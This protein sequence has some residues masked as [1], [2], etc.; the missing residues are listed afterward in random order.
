MGTAQAHGPAQQGAAVIVAG[1]VG[2]PGWGREVRGVGRHGVRLPVA[3][4]AGAMT[5]QLQ[6]VIADEGALGILQAEHADELLL[7]QQGAVQAGA[8]IGIGQIVVLAQHGLVGRLREAQGAPGAQ[9]PDVAAVSANGTER[10]HPQGEHRGQLLAA[11]GAMGL[12]VPEDQAIGPQALLEALQH[13]VIL[14]LAGH[15]AQARQLQGQA[16]GALLGLGLQA[17]EPEGVLLVGEGNVPEEGVKAQHQLAPLAA[18]QPLLD[19]L[20]QGVRQL[21]RPGTAGLVEPVERR[22]HHIGQGD[23]PL[24]TGI[25]AEKQ[26]RLAGGRKM[27]ERGRR[28]ELT[29][30]C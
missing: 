15:L 18:G 22:L 16:G 28:H 20:A 13:G 14:L 5:Y 23:Q 10:V 4:Q 6:G 24:T 11:K 8:D 26:G 25:Q 12:V 29:L 27:A 9:G 3:E 7:L 1:Q 30:S 2:K 21:G 19:R 17:D